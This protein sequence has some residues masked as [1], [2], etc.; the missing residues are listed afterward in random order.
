MRWDFL[1]ISVC[2][3]LVIGCATLSKHASDTSAQPHVVSAGCGAIPGSTLWARTELYFGMQKPDDSF[4]TNDEYQRFL[5]KEVT[6]RFSDGF[7]V[8]EGRGQYLG[9]TGRLWREP[10]KILVLMYPPDP[11]KSTAIDQI[12]SVY[13]AAFQ[14]ESVMRVDGTTC[15]AF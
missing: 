4:T 11:S 3:A 5:D 10:T 8:L 13:K 6:P 7:T 12:R 1:P 2:S 15:V 14:Q 9:P